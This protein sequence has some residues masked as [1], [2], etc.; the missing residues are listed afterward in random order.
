MACHFVG[1][2]SGIKIQSFN[3][4][5][6]KTSIINFTLTGQ[7]TLSMQDTFGSNFTNPEILRSGIF[8]S[9]KLFASFVR[10]V[11]HD[12]LKFVEVEKTAFKANFKRRRIAF[13]SW[14]KFALSKILWLH[15]FLFT[16]FEASKFY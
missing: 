16:T 7:E 13:N 2:S 9:S 8:E 15:D 12:K 4:N 5:V 3:D 10:V 1:N 14:Q 11:P 6:V